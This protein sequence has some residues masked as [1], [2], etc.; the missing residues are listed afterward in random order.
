MRDALLIFGS[1][2]LATK[3]TAVYSADVL[4]FDLPSVHYTGR[5]NNV[6]AVFQPSADFASVDGMTPFIQD[7]A[8]G[9]DWT[10][11]LT[12]HEITAPKEDTQIVLP[13]PVSHKRY[14]RAGATPASS[15]T[16]TAVAVTA[17][18]ELGK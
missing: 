6:C 8:D 4:D 15:G 7:S 17:W 3:N 1:M 2:S 9:S 10:T 13:I 16:L 5:E 11:I 12:G 14:L 18:I